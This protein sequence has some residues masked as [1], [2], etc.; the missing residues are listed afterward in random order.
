MPLRKQVL[1]LQVLS[2][3][4]LSQQVLSLQVFELV[5]EQVFEQLPKPHLLEKN[6]LL[7]INHSLYMHLFMQL[8]LLPLVHIMSAHEMLPIQH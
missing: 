6:L 7:H 4:V 1:P 5:F 8:P 2:L 3:Q